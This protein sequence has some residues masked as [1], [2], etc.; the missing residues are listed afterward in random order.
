VNVEHHH[1]HSPALDRDM[2]LLVFGHAGA[3]LIVFPTSMGSFREWP[4]RRMHE[5]LGEHLRQGWI[6]MFCVDQVH[7]ES[8]YGDHLHPGARAWRHL[9]YDRYLTDELLPFTA[10]KNPNPFVIATGASFGAYHA[11]CLGLRHPHLV[12]RI[13][14]LSGLYDMKRFTDGY[15]DHNVYAANPA[16]FIRHEHDHG[17]LEAMRRQ[18]IILVTGRDDPNSESS[19]ELSRSLWENGVGNALRIWDG[20]CHDWPYWERMITTYIGG[21]D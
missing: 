4:D 14:G 1:W 12:N 2:Q 19:R 7:G 8:W 18:D 6:Q 11:A 13:I 16:D 9:Q 3:R 17:R 15:S 5:V 10:W 21:H 20:W